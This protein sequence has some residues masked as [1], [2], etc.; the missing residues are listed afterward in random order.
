[1][2]NRYAGKSKPVR[3]SVGFS[4][5]EWLAIRKWI[6]AQR[7]KISESEGLR[8]LG[9]LGLSVEAR[10]ANWHSA[11]DRLRQESERAAK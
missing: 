4:R 7:P 5:G 3:K 10:A 6:A 2:A 1:M 8:R 11:K 9:T